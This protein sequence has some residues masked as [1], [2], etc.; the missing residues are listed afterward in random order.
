[1]AGEKES[2]LS[3]HQRQ[4]L[5]L[6]ASTQY[7]TERFYLAGGT[8]LS[9]FYLRHRISEDLDFFSENQEINQFYIIKFFES[10]KNLLKLEKTETK[11]IL[12]LVSLFFHFSDK[13]VLK[14]D[15]NYYPFPKIEKGVRYKGLEIESIYDIAVDKV[16][17]IALN[18]RARD[19]IDIYLVIKEK[20]YD[21]KKL[22]V[23]AKAK[24]DWDISP[25]ELGARLIEGSKLSD[26]PRMLV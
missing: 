8:A 22:I 3:F 12:G 20:K 1:M 5:D 4:I 7:F 13:N 17:T 26:Y 24:F 6:V 10:K 14:V 9:E 11:R 18:P 2:I 25:V 16:H 21:F 23:D 19:Y 15:F